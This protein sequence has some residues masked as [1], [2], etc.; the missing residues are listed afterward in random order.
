MP[1]ATSEVAQAPPSPPEVDLMPGQSEVRAELL[2]QLMQSQLSMGSSH[3]RSSTK[4]V[5]PPRVFK[6][7]I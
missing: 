3:K 1:A 4:T 6:E 7:A 5:L 2:L